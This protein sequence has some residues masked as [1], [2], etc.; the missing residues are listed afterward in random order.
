MALGVVLGAPK[1]IAIPDEVKRTL[2]SV[3]MDICA[4]VGVAAKGP[5]RRP[6]VESPQCL[7]LQRLYLNW[8]NRDRTVATKVTSWDQY[9]QLFGGFEAPGRLPY[10]VANFFEQGGQQAYICRI[11]H[12]YENFSDNQLG[13][14]SCQLPNL[15]N[16]P[17][18]YSLLAKNEGEWGNNLRV[19]A[20]YEFSPVEFHR[21]I[22]S[23]T[24][25]FLD[26]A[27]Q[28]ESA[29][30]IRVVNDDLDNPANNFAEYR[31]V[32]KLVKKGSDN[33]QGGFWEI[34][35]SSQPLP[36]EATS[37]QWV[38]AQVVIEDSRTGQKEGFADLAFSPAHPRFLSR[39]LYQESKLVDPDKESL[40]NPF[41]PVNIHPLEQ[42]LL[43]YSVEYQLALNPSEMKGGADRYQDIN[44]DDFFDPSWVLAN[45]RAGNGI[46]SLTHTRDCS[47]LVVPDLYV[48]ESFEIIES[49]DTPDLLSGSKFA[50]CVDVVQDA[51][52]VEKPLVPL[53]GLLL[54]SRLPT[55]REKII[56]LQKKVVYLASQLRE[57]IALLDVPPN[58]TRHQILQWRTQF[59]SEYSAAYHPWVKVS[60]FDADNQL[61]S[62]PKIINPSAVAAGI[63]A[64]T[65][66]KQGIAVGPANQIAR[67]VFALETRVSSDFHDQVHPLGINVFAAQRDGIWLTAARTLSMQTQ[68]RQLS[69]VRLLAML[70]RALYQQM[71][72]VVFEVNNASLWLNIEFKIE[73]FLRQLYLSGVF[74]GDTQ[75]QAFFVKCN[76]S[77]N[78]QKVID[79]GRLIA[80]IGVAPTEP[81]EF[82]IVQLTRDADGTL[83]IVSQ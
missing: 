42:N 45:E 21:D 77:L 63:I 37:V 50:T 67:S 2:G 79:S 22:S 71:Q 57:F 70:R 80:E 7:D 60:Q 17:E 34:D 36:A 53:R 6:Q 46:H 27:Q 83:K 65:E 16:G 33:N 4:F 31:V 48:P 32:E 82:I 39:V 62:D 23:T 8:E 18:E 49:N 28:L 9:L 13:I 15:T 12:E 59:N 30:L 52:D 56:Y 43:Q 75:Q 26:E 41:L 5:C 78:N 69:V 74:K 11:A 81:M 25:L 10:A 20:G 76:E 68:W 35:L 61:K 54:D 19:A 1:I 66:S 40:V 38:K 73:A 44:H 14:A 24:E 51:L 58:L 47:L 55:D 3:R 64:S 72:W 29:S